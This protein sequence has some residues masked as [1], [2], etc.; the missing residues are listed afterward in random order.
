MSERF[1]EV[2]HDEACCN[3]E[4]KF[5]PELPVFND[6]GILCTLLGPRLNDGIT[7]ETNR[8]LNGKEYEKAKENVVEPY[9]TLPL[10]NSKLKIGWNLVS[11]RAGAHWNFK[12]HWVLGNVTQVH[13]LLEHSS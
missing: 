9:R 10:E 13:K 1:S 11:V 12:R 4:R 8:T 2:I 5:S 3:Q 6:V 7:E